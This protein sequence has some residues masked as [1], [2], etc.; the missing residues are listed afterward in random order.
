MLLAIRVSFLKSRTGESFRLGNLTKLYSENFPILLV[1]K[2]IGP[3]LKLV[4]NRQAD[5]KSAGINTQPRKSSSPIISA[6]WDRKSF[7]AARESKAQ[8]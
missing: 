5:T 1:R 3:V 8:G 4:K 7:F 2:S 6:P